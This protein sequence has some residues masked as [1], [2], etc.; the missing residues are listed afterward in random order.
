MGGTKY[1][2]MLPIISR[3]RPVVVASLARSPHHSGGRDHAT[4]LLAARRGTA[5]RGMAHGM[6]WRGVS[7]RGRY[8]ARFG[9]AWCGM[10]WRGSGHGVVWRG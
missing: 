9:V 8:M 6:M 10:A 1:T 4:T 3:V 7:W 2:V 5:G